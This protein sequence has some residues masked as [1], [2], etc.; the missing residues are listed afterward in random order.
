MK[1]IFF[2]FSCKSDWKINNTYYKNDDSATATYL[3]LRGD[4]GLHNRPTTQTIGKIV[5]KFEETGV[6]TNIERPVHHSFARYADNFATVT[7]SIAE[8]PNM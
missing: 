1:Q 4:Y 8:D 7:E 2:L 3:A 5:N 6:V